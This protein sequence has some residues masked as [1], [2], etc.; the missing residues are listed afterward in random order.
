M[1]STTTIIPPA[2]VSPVPR[3]APEPIELIPPPWR[4]TGDVYCV[5]FW[6]PAPSRAY[7]K[8]PGH[9]YSPLEAG[10]EFA[11]PPGSRPAGGL[12]MIQIIRYHDSPVGPYDEM[13]VVPGSFDWTRRGPGGRPEK[14]CN[15]RISRI[16]VS[17]KQS[18]FNGRIS[19]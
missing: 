9:A 8:L 2:A 15:P 19:M 14:G 13:L 4:V 7:P 18:C 10:A 6:S 5:S 11:S 12:G 3:R 17:Q 1:T 16:Y